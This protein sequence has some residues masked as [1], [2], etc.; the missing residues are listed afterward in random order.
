MMQ[1]C[2]MASFSDAHECQSIPVIAAN[3]Q[4]AIP[5]WKSQIWAVLRASDSFKRLYY[6]L[7]NT[8]LGRMC[9]SGDIYD[10]SE[11]QWQVITDSIAFY[12][13]VSPVLRF[14]KSVRFGPE[15]R[16]YNR[17]EGWQAVARTYENQ[18]LLVVHC[19]GT[20]AENI[21]LPLAG[22]K[23]SGF[24][25]EHPEKVSVTEEGVVIR[26]AEEFSACVMI[27]ERR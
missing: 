14:G 15:I 21:E 11:E 27:L 25:G 8:F 13:R 3:V 1:L 5:A 23:L 16:S 4:R 9:L 19:F 12:K 2:D 10:L 22:Q 17:L 18:T 7:A 24:F 6:S 20:P 26:N